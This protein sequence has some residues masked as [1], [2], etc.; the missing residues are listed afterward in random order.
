MAHPVRQLCIQQEERQL[1]TQA[2]GLEGCIGG[3]GPTWGRSE[4]ALRRGSG[5][6]RRAEGSLAVTVPSP[7]LWMAGIP[8]GLGQSCSP[9]SQ[10][11]PPELLQVLWQGAPEFTCTPST[12]SMG[13]SAWHIPEV[14]LILCVLLW[15][16]GGNWLRSVSAFLV[17]TDH[18]AAGS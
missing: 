12:L 6:C 5:R 11:R 17:A 15:S 13:E 4:A 16:Q 8:R 18:C 2:P 9:G 7:G 10:P 14:C 1:Q 3:G